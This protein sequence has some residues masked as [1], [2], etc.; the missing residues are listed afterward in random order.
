MA[1]VLDAMAPYVNNLIMDMAK[2]EVSMLLGV[3]GEILKLEGNLDNLKAF[4]ADAERK[5]IADETVQRWV[6][7][8]KNAMYEATDI[9]D[10]CNIEADK[11]MGSKGGILEGK[12]PSCFQPLLL[13]LRNPMF[14]HEIGSRIKELNHRGDGIH[15]E[16]KKFNFID[17][18]RSYPEQRMP[19]NARQTS[20][21]MT[22]EFD[23]SSI[24]G[25]KIETETRELAQLLITNRNHNIK[26][27]SIVGTGGIGK[28]TLAQKIFNDTT[29][30]F[31][32]TTVQEHFKVKI[33]LSITQ[34]F[35]EAVLLRIAIE[36]AGGVHGGVQDKMLLT[37]TL[38][39]TLS[40]DRF[41]LVLDDLWSDEAWS[42]V[43]SVPIKKAS[44][45]HAGNWVLITTRL[46]DLA[47]HMGASFYQHHVSPLNEEDAWS[48]LKKQLPPSPSEGLFGFIDLENYGIKQLYIIRKV[49]RNLGLEIRGPGWSSEK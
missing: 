11:P 4:L 33:W 40:K 13:C 12:V 43:L 9:L 8:L 26:V 22:S 46:E 5:R 44:Q 6:M 15:K 20:Q 30:I 31:D 37:R 17:L 10:L 47:Q 21:K 28:T 24:V 23:E 38:I 32:D 41:F 27:V 16:A 45:K 35:D 36:H 42:H 34:H 2:E 19:S 49:V 1:A 25:E 18:G 14:A 48:L 3:S 7:K 29:S 39:D